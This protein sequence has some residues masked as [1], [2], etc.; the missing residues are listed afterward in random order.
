LPLEGLECQL[1]KSVNS[2]TCP[3]PTTHRPSPAAPASNTAA[4]FLHHRGLAEMHCKSVQRCIAEVSTTSS[5]QGWPRSFKLTQQ[6]E[7]KFLLEA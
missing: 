3:R 1:F 6:F 5:S 4:H 7:W 2:D